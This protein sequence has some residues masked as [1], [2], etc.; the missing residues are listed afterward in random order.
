M[1]KFTLTLALFVGVLSAAVAQSTEPVKEKSK[2]EI[3]PSKAVVITEKK[4][5]VEVK[6]VNMKKVEA[7]PKKEEAVIEEKETNQK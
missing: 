5:A 1:R 2:Q 6:S 7:L 4:P 3:K